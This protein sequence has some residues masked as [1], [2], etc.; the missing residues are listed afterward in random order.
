MKK[1]LAI[2]FISFS[3]A[4]LAA[5]PKLTPG[6]RATDNRQPAIN[7]GQ[8]TTDNALPHLSLDSTYLDIGP[9]VIDSIGEGVMHFRNTGKAP[10]TILQVFSECGCTVPYYSREPVAPGETG[11]IRVR[12]KSKGSVPG[13]FRKALRIRSNADNM[14]QILVI[15]G[16]VV[17]SGGK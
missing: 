10:L 9:V 6:N 2:L 15:K 5:T 13:S 8:P 14:R 4:A 16:K 11:E 3:V 7:T 17:E 12:Y 1:I